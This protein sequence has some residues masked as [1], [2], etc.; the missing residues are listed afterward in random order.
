MIPETGVIVP[1]TDKSIVTTNCMS[2][3]YTAENNGEVQNDYYNYDDYGNKNYYVAF[4][5]N[6]MCGT[7]YM[8][9]RKCESQFN[10]E[11]FPYPETGACTYIESVKRLKADGIIRADQKVSSRPAAVT[12]GVFTTLAS[13]SEG[14]CTTSRARLPSRE[15]TLLVPLQVSLK[16]WHY[17]MSCIQGC[18][19][20]MSSLCWVF[21]E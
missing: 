7:M 3:K 4:E 21:R 1:F 16:R 13:L 12:I 8:S 10:K 17:L 9:S 6:E 19:V 20:L 11:D 2:C 14:I 18:G 5:V 15:S